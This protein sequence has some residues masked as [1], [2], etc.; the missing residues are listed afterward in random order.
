M[1]PLQRLEALDTQ[2]TELQRGPPEL[3]TGLAPTALRQRFFGDLALFWSEADESGQTRQQ[4]LQ[5][6]RHEQLLAELELRLADKTLDDDHIAL[7]RTSL[8]LPL[9]WQR[10]HLPAE[11]RAQ[12][13]RPVFSSLSPNRRLALPGA[14]VLIADGPPGTAATP[15]ETTGKALLCSLSHGI[16][17]FASLADLH[18]ELCERLDDPLQSEPLLQLLPRQEDRQLIQRADRL[19]YE[20]FAEDMVAQQA[21]DLIDV[22]RQRLMLAWR[23]AWEPDQAPDPEDVK[24]LLNEQQALLGLM[25]SQRA[26]A[27]RYALL[28]EKHLPSWLRNAS[29]RS[30]AHIMQTLQ[31][32]AG[33]ITQA[34]APGILTLEQFNNRNH[35]LAWVRDRL[36]HALRRE[37]G[38]HTPAEHIRIHVTL[39][40]RRGPLLHPLQPSSYV[41][42]ASRPHVGDTVELV[43]VSYGLD[44]LA[45]LNIAWFDVDYWL[46]ARVQHEDGS[47]LPGLTPLK[48]KQLVRELDA[49][50]GYLHYLR[51]QLLDSFAGQ[52]RMQAHG[53]IN[54]ARMH[55]E[56]AKAR[57]AKHF[58]EDPLEQGY[59]WARAIIHYPN[60]NWR[61][62]IETHRI[63]VRQLLIE[64]H[65][66][67]GVLLL[68]AEVASVHSLVVYTP[69]APDRRAWRE[70]RNTRE[71]L[72]TLRNTPTLRQYLIQRAPHADGERFDK[73]MRKGR[74]GPYVERPVITGNVYEARYQAEVQALMAEANANSR[75][76]N[77]VLG[78]FG[79]AT[80]RLILDLVSLVL[81]APALSALAFG[82]MAISIWD[83]LDAMH[84]DDH[85]A[86]LHH[87]IAALSH[88][89]DGLNSFAGSTLMRRALRGLPP[90]PP[91]PLPKTI[92]APID[93]S[94][95]R[96]RIDGVYGEEVY[97]QI[98]EIPGPDRYF[99]KDNQGRLY[100]VNFDGHRWRALDP[101]QPDAYVQLPLKRLRDGTW[102][103]DLPVL[104]HDGLPDLQHVLDDCRL[105]PARDGL[106]IAAEAD[107]FDDDGQLYLQL[108][109]RQ[110]PVRRHLLAGHY[111]LVLAGHTL[112]AVHAW[113]VL[114]RQDGQWRIR[115]RQ[116]GR[117]SD[118]LA[119]PV[120]YS[121]NRGSSR[122]SR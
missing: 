71:L 28:L 109:G 74:L 9:P 77:E 119:L 122:S 11:H 10:Q 88:T 114:R 46:T 20:W 97:E 108:A 54:R 27:T 85:E 94:K 52:W 120:D 22:Q 90:Q 64:G 43:P 104:W 115:V 33:A 51:H 101:R 58:L 107:L 48:V 117:S 99:V 61:P 3:A 38:I 68:N 1:T 73:L 95:L 92:E 67:Q 105:Q 62:T 31:E 55:A 96:Y 78:E 91:R 63:V 56:A 42:A 66:L 93:I 29:A 116:P 106:P 49:G 39:A 17:A 113:A 57:Y 5:Q 37:H 44:E 121:D 6:L 80:L 25:G 70:F 75:S 111:H 7:L 53:N 60:S 102:V 23:G 19:R 110:L 65:T 15:G 72:R 4:R 79:L 86:V 41:A 16:E 8:A 100:N 12:F 82:R 69:D 13:Y 118:W 14:L 59:R 26:L 83:G 32:L 103:V 50:S 45:L 34:A 81:P 24:R 87:A 30:L 35:L 76:N 112:G 89:T 21:R 98:S 84:R 18:V 36:G 47:A 2:I 40:R